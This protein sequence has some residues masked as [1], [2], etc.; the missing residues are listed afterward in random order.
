MERIADACEYLA[1]EIV[2]DR[3]EFLSEHREGGPMLWEGLLAHR[4]ARATIA[5]GPNGTP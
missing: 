2:V 5:F 4:F 1:R 3:D